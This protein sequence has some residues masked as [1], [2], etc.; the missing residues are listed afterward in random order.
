MSPSQLAVCT[1]RPSANFNLELAVMVVHP[2]V[3]SGLW[4][5]ER[6]AEQPAENVPKGTRLAYSPFFKG[7]VASFHAFEFAKRRFQHRRAIDQRFIA[8]RSRTFHSDRRA[9]TRRDLARFF[10]CSR[11]LV[12]LV[13]KRRQRIV[14]GFNPR[15]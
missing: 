14:V 4:F 6:S 15:N 11:Y 12:V 10:G 3:G 7:R 2:G 9:K 13:A 8:A 5:D 1:D